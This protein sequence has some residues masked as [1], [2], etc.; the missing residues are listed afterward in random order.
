MKSIIHEQNIQAGGWRIR[1]DEFVEPFDSTKCQINIDTYY[2]NIQPY[3]KHIIAPFLILSFDIEC[4]SSHG[5]FPVP[6]KTFK[7]IQMKLL[8]YMTP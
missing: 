5:D 6:K 1:I 7:N 2:E 3:E 8:I 4:S